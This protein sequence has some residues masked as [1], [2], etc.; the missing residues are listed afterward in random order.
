MNDFKA[1]SIQLTPA[2]GLG[3]VFFPLSKTSEI[4]I[5]HILSY[6]KFH[7]GCYPF[8]RSSQT[9]IVRV[10]NSHQ[11]KQTPHYLRAC[12]TVV[13]NLSYADCNTYPNTT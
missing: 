3:I 10:W 4:Y 2:S 7:S 13:G 12:E 8:R 9:K 5:P 6:R 11:Q 1:S